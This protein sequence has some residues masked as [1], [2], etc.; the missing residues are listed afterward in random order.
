MLQTAPIQTVFGV[1]TDFLASNPDAEAIIAYRLPEDLQA[2]AH[3]LLERN[4]EG[5]LTFDEEQEMFDFMRMD[6]MM[7]LLKAKTRLKLRKSTE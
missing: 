2:R 5:L 4:G 7:A 6:E 3:D 1:I